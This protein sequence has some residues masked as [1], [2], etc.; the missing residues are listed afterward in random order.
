VRSPAES[1]AL[2]RTGPAALAI[3]A[4]RRL[5]LPA[6]LALID[7][8]VVEAIWRAQ[9]AERERPEIILVSAPP[10]HGK[11]TLVSEYLPAWFLG[12]F[13]ERRVIL[14]SYEADFAA[15]WGAKT[16]TLLE[17]HGPDLYRVRVDERSRS[18][19]RW[20]LHRRPGGMVT[21][22]VGGPITGRGAHLLVIDDPIKNAEQAASP[23]IRE[24]QWDWWLSTAR[25]RLEP[26]AVVVVVMT[27]WHEADLAG[28]LLLASSEG[29]DPV[30]EIRLPALAE[31]GDP[32]RRDPGEA[33]WPE[34]F[35]APYL[36]QTRK[37]LGPYWFAAIYQGR[38]TPEEGGIFDRKDF[39]YFELRG[40]QVVLRQPGGRKAFGR[41][42]C[43]KF[44]VVDL[45]ASE[46]E[47]ADY[48]V[49]AE[50][51]A[52]PESDLL[53]RS[54][55]RQRVAVPD[56]PAFFRQHHAGCPVKFE[57]I[58]YQFGIVQ[59]MLRD[60]FP[61]EPVHPDADKVTR[62]GA[63]GVLYRQG[64]VYHLAGAPWLAD[65]EAELLA[66]PAGEHDDQ[67][68]AIAYGAKALP[69]LGGGG[70]RQKSRGRTI[71]GGL[72]E[73]EF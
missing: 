66:F 71:T 50:L 23:T 48:T 14:T 28:K 19:S 16:R 8:A 4:N 58:G 21:A 41:D 30:T 47:T 68:D 35:P 56:Q 22:G 11:S 20:D 49:I 2:A 44:Q 52:T 73:M 43:Q 9:D 37:T 17:E 55:V 65:F 67:V 61:A 10:R 13:P 62:A 18:A 31:R 59:T 29:G 5:H 27:R 46:K 3:L 24:K 39:R 40:D 34:R 6:H 45:A 12:A 57:A 38:P 70:Y 53:V 60:G 42:W 51:W 33:L 54:V 7:E 72:M 25:T 64:K 26:G 1:Q 63:A 36:E 32:L 69:H 15:G